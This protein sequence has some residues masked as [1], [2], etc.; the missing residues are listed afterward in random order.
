M[1]IIISEENCVGC[2]IC[3]DL[4]PA[5]EPVLELIDEVAVVADL[6]NCTECQACAVNCEYDA[7]SYIE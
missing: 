1:E 4:C 2:G 7:V 6:D 3:I 5:D